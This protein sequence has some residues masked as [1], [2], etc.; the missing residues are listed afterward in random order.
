MCNPTLTPQCVEVQTI[1]GRIKDV[2]THNW[3][4]QPIKSVLIIT[5]VVTA[6]TPGS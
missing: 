3:V 2:S 5:V 4:N 6:T 1:I